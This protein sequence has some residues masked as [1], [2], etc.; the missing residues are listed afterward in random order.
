MKIFQS[1]QKKGEILGISQPQQSTQNVPINRKS[2]SI[3][4]ILCVASFSCV[5]YFFNEASSVQE[6]TICILTT[7]TLILEITLDLISLCLNS[8]LN[9]HIQSFEELIN[10]SEFRHN[11]AYFYK[12]ELRIYSTK[13]C[14]F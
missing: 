13:M 9:E 3:L 11:L 7:S 14:I 2:A 8:S 1:I 12:T 5:T 4:L 6:Y 10:K